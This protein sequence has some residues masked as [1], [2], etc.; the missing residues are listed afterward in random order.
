MRGKGFSDH[1]HTVFSLFYKSVTD[2][3]IWSE[4]MS[5][6]TQTAF[7]LFLHNNNNQQSIFYD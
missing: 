6:K 5:R 7:I 4:H 2:M 1:S 3:Q